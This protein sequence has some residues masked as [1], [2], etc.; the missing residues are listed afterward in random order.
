MADIL[1]FITDLTLHDYVI[2][3]KGQFFL[4]YDSSSFN[5]KAL[6]DILE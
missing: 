4:R 6:K 2:L 5:F 1:K 3:L